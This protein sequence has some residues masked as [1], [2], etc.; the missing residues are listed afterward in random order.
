VEAAF[1]KLPQHWKRN[2]TIISGIGIV[3]VLVL[4]GGCMSN[5]EP[6][7]VMRAHRGAYVVHMSE[8]E[9]FGIVRTQLEA[10]GLTF[11]AEPPAYSVDVWADAVGI[12]LFDSYLNVAVAYFSWEDSHLSLMQEGRRFTKWIA[13]EFAGQTD[14]VVGVFYAPGERLRGLS[15]STITNMPSR[16]T[17]NAIVTEFRPI[18]EAQLNEQINDFIEQLRALEIIE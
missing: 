1:M 5:R 9:A 10:A 6:N 4:L 15:L 12:D 2:I 14:T 17:V 13:D 3:A 7:L 18:F 16:R 11:N 8:E